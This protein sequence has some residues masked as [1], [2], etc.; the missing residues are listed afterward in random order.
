[1][2]RPANRFDLEVRPPLAAD[3]IGDANDFTSPSSSD[4]TPSSSNISSPSGNVM[5]LPGPS[6]RYSMYDE[7]KLASRVSSRSVTSSVPLSKA[8]SIHSSSPGPALRSY[9]SG[10]PRPASRISSLPTGA[11]PTLNTKQSTSG[12]SFV[13]N[14][15]PHGVKEVVQYIS[16]NDIINVADDD[17]RDKSSEFE[18]RYTAVECDANHFPSNYS[19]RTMENGRNIKVFIVVTMYNEDMDEL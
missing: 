2:S 11:L 1:V 12:R 8:F 17:Y 10:L 4:A 7:G 3:L 5:P 16:A 18:M 14:S 19:L 6:H 9:N 13:S 15:N